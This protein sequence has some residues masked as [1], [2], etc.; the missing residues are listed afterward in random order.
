MTPIAP[1]PD[2]F[3]SP[4]LAPLFEGAPEPVLKAMMAGS[5]LRHLHPGDRLL[6]KGDENDVLFLV[7]AGTLHVRIPGAARTI[8]SV[9]PGEC[10]GELSLIDGFEVS[11]DVFADGEV[12]VLAIEREQLWHVIE[13]APVVAR[14]LLRML[15]RRV[16]NDNRRLQDADRMQ[17]KYEKAATV[18]A[19][20]G[21]RNRRW[22]NEAF[23]RQLQRTLRSGQPVSVLMID[24]DHFKH[25]NDTHGHLVGDEVL[26]HVGRTLATGL[27]PQDLLA[28]YGGEE[29]AVLLPNVPH[30]EA[31]AAADRL[32]K[33]IEAHPPHTSAGVLMLPPVTVSIGVATMMPGEARPLQQLIDQADAA[34]GTAKTDGR[35]CIRG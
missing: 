17:R 4:N 20:T 18:D 10:V 13:T 24:A 35:N 26:V 29:F 22:L 7:L 31:L 19:L 1:D 15:A 11:A 33:A 6:A 32:R 8:V 12:L 27:R 25:V 9:T 21:L 28:R 5:E 34:L 30:T 2:I 16:R 14:N 3:A 23:E